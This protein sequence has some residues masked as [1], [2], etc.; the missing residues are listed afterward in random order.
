MFSNRSKW[1]LAVGVPAVL[2]G[3]VVAQ[4]SKGMIAGT[5]TDN[6]G[7][8]LPNATVN[9]RSLDTGESR[10]ITTGPSGAY[11][12]EAVNP[13]NYNITVT[14]SGFQTFTITN[15]EVVASVITPV[16]AHLK[17][18]QASETVEVASTNNEVETENGQLSANIS[19][20]EVTQLPIVSLN[21]IEIVLTEPGMTDA[22]KRGLSNGVNF[23][24][25]GQRTRSNNFLM[26]GQDNNDKSIGGQAF[27]PAN[28]EAIQEVTILT[29][30]FSAE[31]GGGAATVTNLI[32]KSGTNQFHGSV[33]EYYQGSG[34]NAI[35]AAN[36]LV[37]NQNFNKAR[38]DQHTMGFTIGGPIKK[39]KLF[40]FFSPQWQRYYGN[41]TSST[42][43][44]PT[45]QGIADL[46]AYGSANA[47]L[48]AQFYSGYQAPGTGT[49]YYTQT[50]NTGTCIHMGLVNRN[51]AQQNP[52]TQY[53]TKLDY[54]PTQSDSLSL[55]YIHNYGARNPDF[56]NNPAALPGFE[57]M[58]SGPSENLGATWTHT[59]NPTTVNEVRASWG[60]FNLTFGP[61]PQAAANPLFNSPAIAISDLTQLPT[62]GFYNGMP[63]GRGHQTYQFQDAL[64][65]TSGKHTFKMGADLSRIIVHDTIPFTSRGA[66][67]YNPGGGY[68]GLGNFLDNYS[69]ASGSATITYGNPVVN[70][71]MWQEGFYFQDSWKVKENLTVDLGMRYEFS[72]NPENLL[73]YP[74]INPYTELNST[75]YS[76]Q[77]VRE[78]GNNWGPR[79]G[80][81]Y[82]PK[83]FGKF[84]GEGKTVV[85]GGYGI[86]YDQFFTNILDNS[87]AYSPNAITSLAQATNSGRG[88]ANLSGQIASLPATLNP[89]SSVYTVANNLV[90]PLTHQWNLDIEREL[91]GNMLATIAYVGSHSEHEYANMQLNPNGGLS[92]TGT[93][94]PRL[95]PSRGSIIYRNNGASAN[96]NALDVKVERRFSK[97]L[98]L[99]GSYTF[100]RALD[101][102]SEVYTLSGYGSSLPQNGLSLSQALHQDYGLSS[103]NA[104]QRFV[105]A[106]VYE[107]PSLSFSNHLL[108]DVA[109][110]T[111]GWQWSNTA[112]LQSGL[113]YTPY[114]GGI[115]TNGDG[116]AY[117]GR[118]NLGNPNAPIGTTG[119][120]GIFLGKGYTP[121]V[122]YNYATKQATTASQVHW[123]VQP[124]NGNVSRNSYYGPG[125]AT[126]NMGLARDFKVPHVTER[127][128]LQL[129]ADVLDV[130]N[131]AND[132]N[133]L[134]MNVLQVQSTTNPYGNYFGNTHYAR[135]GSRTM[136][137]E[138]KFTF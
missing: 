82:T 84:L 88:I 33:W 78:D 79:V 107:L 138:A 72:N 70:A 74:A 39:D 54:L 49:C 101:D 10:S 55:R 21:P 92:S 95:D 16:D 46:Q 117:N 128:Q 118:P 12:I 96:Y 53:V 13:G 20:V 34:L 4:T 36:G 127:S 37:A 87:A 126:W 6:T 65:K 56:L 120:D 61:T 38:Y 71:K 124:G 133:A 98:M 81:A 86:F 67:T 137:L 42:V 29:N 129:R 44:A 135:A 7:A 102:A 83:F 5:V 85:R 125:T 22:G 119:V 47:N 132:T 75:G 115:D 3:T 91:P 51:V 18:G 109:Y 64:T 28:P 93:I 57:S 19:S 136:R 105:V 113:P 130:L 94:L 45:S 11:R 27:Q 30:S 99:R 112:S 62:L 73:P 111:R 90:N 63:Q 9:V 76:Y 40:F 114:V 14:A 15:R 31:F 66:L 35:D 24:S 17:I 122:L 100:S 32:T 80:F 8:A 48:L 1:S 106:A 59:F 68:T 104:N 26:D 97:G 89:L 50:G 116:N 60:H 77:R 110:A 121:G 52:Q 41:A 69:G 131:H 123:L 2:I 58:Q 103:Y 134:N 43:L 108:N 23:S 25:G